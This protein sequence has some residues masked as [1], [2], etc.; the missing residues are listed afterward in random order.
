MVIAEADKEVYLKWDAFFEADV[1]KQGLPADVRERVLRQRHLGVEHFRIFEWTKIVGELNRDYN[2]AV[3]EGLE[4]HW[5]EAGSAVYW[6][7]QVHMQPVETGETTASGVPIRELREVHGGWQPTSPLPA[8][9]ASSIAN[10]LGMGLRLRP[11]E[12]GVDVEVL[13]SAVTVDSLQR[14]DPPKETKTYICQRHGDLRKFSTWKAYIRH[15]ATKKEALEE[16]PPKEVLE[17]ARKYVY[18][19]YQHNQG[20][21]NE[22][23]VKRHLRTELRKPGRAVH[24]SLEQMQMQ[25]EG[26]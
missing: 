26:G 1:D 16:I 23:L 22:R 2:Y 7:K 9:S 24:L 19:C 6:Q 13:E 8:N 3:P 11:P 25:K 20:F 14:P 4:P 21:N 15:C 17:M 18:Y 12:A 5:V 10:F